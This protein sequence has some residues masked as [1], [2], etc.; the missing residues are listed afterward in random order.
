MH[1]VGRAGGPGQCRCAAHGDDTGLVLLRRD[2]VGRERHSGVGK[3]G[4]HIHAVLVEPAAQNADADIR[5]VLVIGRNDLHL[6]RWV[7]RHELRGGLP[8]SRDPVR[9][10]QAAIG[11][12]KIGQH[13]D[14]DHRR[15]RRPRAP[16]CRTRRCRRRAEH[17]PSHHLHGDFPV[18]YIARPL[19]GPQLFGALLPRTSVSA[20]RSINLMS[21]E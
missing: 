6:D 11:A 5:L 9:P 14:L 21:A 2:V 19:I 17:G 3:I 7:G 12:R 8:G 4:Y 18:V 20:Q 13:P 10:A 15:L 1:K 16:E